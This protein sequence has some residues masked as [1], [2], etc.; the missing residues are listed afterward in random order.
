MDG[1]FVDHLSMGEDHREQETGGLALHRP[2]LHGLG[3]PPG[4]ILVD[5]TAMGQAATDGLPKATASSVRI[6]TDQ[7][8]MDLL[9]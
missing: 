2:D 4:G 9:G 3:S 7:I 5:E 1:I 8:S 6:S